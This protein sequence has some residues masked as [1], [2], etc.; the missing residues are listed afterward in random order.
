MSSN[1][2]LYSELSAL[3]IDDNP[4]VHDLLKRA[5]YQLGIT[6]V[7][8]A[9]NSYYGLSLCNSMH[10]NIVVIAYN[11]KS[12]RD[13]FHLLEEMQFKGFINKKTILIFLSIDT[14]ETLVNS[15]AELQPDD[16]WVKPLNVKIVQ[17]R[18]SKVIEAKMALRDVFGCFDKKDFGKAV[19]YVER[20]TKLPQFKKYHLN[21]LRM[22]GDCLINLFEFEEAEGFYR[23]LMKKHKN[24]WV[25]L[26]YVNSLLKQDKIEEINDLLMKL[27]E[28]V[29]T[30]F[31]TYDLLAQ[32]YVEKEDFA[33]A[34]AEIKKAAH[35]AP[36]NLARNKKVW[37]LAR[38]NHDQKEQYLAT[39]SMA[40]NAKNSI[41]DSPELVLNVIRSAVDL[42]TSSDDNQGAN[43]LKEAEK[44]I[45]TL[46]KDY[47]D[48][49]Q[50]KEQ[51][52]VAQARILNARQERAKAK[53]LVEM[54][55]SPRPTISVEDNLDKVK[56]YH[57]LGMREEALSL[58]AAVKN[59]IA[60]DT[61]AGA[62][63]TKFVEQE[64][65][66]KSEIHFTPQQ[67]NSMAVEFFK[68]QK[69]EPA[70]TSLQQ[71]L[72]LTPNNVKTALSLLKVLVAIYRSEGLTNQ[73]KAIAQSTLNTIDNLE[74][75]EIQ[76]AYFAELSQ[77]LSEDV[78][79]LEA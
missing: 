21:L 11:V 68:K 43:L 36:R 28:K 39:Q 65:K 74:M 73:H 46:Q 25:Y 61:L 78:L 71:A 79:K 2:E 58:L 34:Y 27:T 57:E 33:K 29:E 54:Q 62:V 75:D 70:L 19:Y 67:L 76:Q 12:D 63:T 30:R 26:G 64:T 3:V 55:V 44:Y 60:C 10:F 51:L 18:L 47:K 5:L 38:L 53:R 35:L 45:T 50:F 77:E 72:Q 16:F 6:N 37:D 15:V 24:A 7:R 41:H 42:A 14:D 40:K 4:I 20:Y 23:E 1:E 17:E 56:I 52:V 66:E 32:Y 22:K 31:A 8:C 69:L 13:G 59:Q 48:A 9:E 49:G